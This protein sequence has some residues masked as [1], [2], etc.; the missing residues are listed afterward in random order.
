MSIACERPWDGRRLHFVG[1]GRRR[2]ER[3][4]AR[5]PRAR[6]AGQR[7]RSAR[8][9]LYRAPGRRRRAAR[10][11][12]RSR[13]RERASGRGRRGRLLERRPAREPRARRGPRA[14]S[15]RAS[16][17]R[18]AGRAE[19]SATHDRR[20]GHARQDD[21]LGDARRGAAGRRPASPT[22]SSAA[23]WG[24][25]R[26]TRAGLARESGWSSRPT[27]PT[28][29]CSRSTWIS[30]CSRTSSWTTMRRSA[31]WPSCARRSERSWRGRARRSSCGTAPSCWRWRPSGPG[32]EAVAG[33]A[34]GDG[35]RVQ[36]AAGAEAGAQVGIEIVP[37][38][39]PRPALTDGG[40]H[41]DLA[42]PRGHAVGAGRAQRAERDGRA[43]GRPPGRGGRAARDRGTRRRFTARAGAF[44]SLGKSG[45]R[46]ARV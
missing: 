25:G 40:S 45:A 17:R 41:F 8:L 44:S 34:I 31:R 3:L 32:S 27:S 14:R 20:R 37:Y 22:G 43:G 15:A 11:D 29:R 24:R 21:D 35:A 46:R 18:A 13:R 19:R 6:R 42:R 4:R 30:R 23:R 38:D 10:P 26:T 36:G 5:G 12:R 7:L 39:A 1:V 33:P 16:A 9:P 28:A 2:H